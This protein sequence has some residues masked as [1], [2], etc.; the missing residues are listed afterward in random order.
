MWADIQ[1]SIRTAGARGSAIAMEIT[2]KTIYDH[3]SIEFIAVISDIHI[4][5]IICVPMNAHN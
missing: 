2:T 3:L 1:R 4:N 5:T